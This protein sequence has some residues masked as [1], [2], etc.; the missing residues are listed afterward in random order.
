MT[1]FTTLP[2]ENKSTETINNSKNGVANSNNS[3]GTIHLSPIAPSL[4]HPKTNLSTSFPVSVTS[5]F[6]ASG[7][8]FV[9]Q[10][11]SFTSSGKSCGGSSH[12]YPYQQQQLLQYSQFQYHLSTQ[13]QHINYSNSFQSAQTSSTFHSST[14]A[15]SFT[16]LHHTNS[17]AS[18][19]VRQP[20]YHQGSQTHITASPTIPSSQLYSQQPQPPSS[21]LPPCPSVVSKNESAAA[22]ILLTKLCASLLSGI[23]EMQFT[24][25]TTLNKIIDAS[26]VHRI[27]DLAVNPDAHLQPSSTER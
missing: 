3:S 13:P 24:A 12:S 1:V 2:T 20:L 14:S 4:S 23:Q 16:S 21:P 6:E 19:S 11:S 27:G 8:P 10:N 26:I 7:T 15:H 25:M 22:V 5:S 17:S 9:P 18:L